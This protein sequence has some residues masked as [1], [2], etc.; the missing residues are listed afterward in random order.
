MGIGRLGLLMRELARRIFGIGIDMLGELVGPS[1]C[2]ACD[3][4]QRG[5]FCS[6]CVA[7]VEKKVVEKRGVISIFEYGGAIAS[8]IRRFKYGGRSELGARLGRAMAESVVETLDVARGVDLVLPVP[9]H[10]IRLVER[11][12]N[13]SLLLARPVARILKLP[14]LAHALL[15]VRHTPRQVTLDRIERLANLYD[16][17]EFGVRPNGLGVRDIRDARILLIDDVCTT[18]AT[19][20]GCARALIEAGARTVQALVLARAS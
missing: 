20:D 5:L 17:F 3:V 4:R 14:L 10:P 19:I 9:L 8:A 6:A 1:G 18:G 13:Q 15:R 12:Y 16:A 2:V 7:A 11:G